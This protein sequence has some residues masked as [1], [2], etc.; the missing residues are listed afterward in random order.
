MSDC[1]AVR[2]EASLR[3]LPSW[4]VARVGKSTLSRTLTEKIEAFV[5]DVMKKDHIPGLSLAVV[6]NGRVAYAK[7][8][9]A[10]NLKANLPATPDTLYEI[11]SVTKSFTALA[12]MQLQA[13]RK[14][15]VGDP[16]GK[17]VPEFKL[18]SESNPIRIRHLLSHSSGVP[19]LGV[20]LIHILRSLEVDEYWIP[21]SS[22]DDLLTHINGAKD[23]V[24]AAPG[25]RFFYFNEGFNLLGIIV[26]RV[27][28]V[29]YGE[30]VSEQILKPLGMNRSGFPDQMSDEEGDVATPYWIQMKEKRLVATPTTPP[31]ASFK[32]E[33]PAGGMMS[34]VLELSKYLIANLNR[35]KFE[36]GR[37]LN[38]KGFAELHEPRMKTG[39]NS[40]FGGP[41]LYGYGWEIVN[42]F[43]GHRCI[44]HSGSTFTGS[45]AVEFLPDLGTGVAVASNNGAADSVSSTIPSFVLALLLGKDPIKEVPLLASEERV[46][47]LVGDYQT[48]KGV[49]RVSV[50]EKG[51]V[52]L[53][54]SKDPINEGTTIALI[55]EEYDLSTWRFHCFLNRTKTPVEFVIGPSGKIDLYIEMGRYQK[56]S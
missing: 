19:D 30:H 44:G 45:A 31:L 1:G 17:Y 9:G 29:S 48:Y 13:Q 43:F 33:Y 54:E 16:V 12:V 3:E 56:A 47:Q 23:W 34:S 6:R 24:A 28:G 55:P 27:S 35:G 52:L 53:L 51:G 8:F 22:V 4:G 42:D 5:A 2:N 50:S 49:S 38:P 25:E 11:G 32:W 41:S 18:G 10:R 7:G 40:W 39:Q 36:G 37:L 21:V 26:E 46:G 14:L 15:N 20:A